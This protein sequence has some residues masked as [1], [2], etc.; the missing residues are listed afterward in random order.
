MAIENY[1]SG[2]DRAKREGF[3][4]GESAGDESDFDHIRHGLNNTNSRRLHPCIERVLLAWPGAKPNFL[5]LG[6]GSGVAV[7]QVSLLAPNANIHTAMSSTAINPYW[8]FSE[9]IISHRNRYSIPN[10][11]YFGIRAF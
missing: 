4:H 10:I 5:E 3:I 6:P 1:L 7:S 8:R 2:I 9:E 11:V